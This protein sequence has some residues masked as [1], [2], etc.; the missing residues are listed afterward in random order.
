MPRKA[1]TS[2]ESIG[3]AQKVLRRKFDATVLGAD[4]PF[5]DRIGGLGL[6]SGDV[7]A[8]RS[9]LLDR[10]YK[11]VKAGAFVMFTQP[12][13]RYTG[14]G[15]TVLGVLD[16]QSPW[17]F[18][19]VK[20]QYDDEARIDLQAQFQTAYSIGDTVWWD[21]SSYGQSST[22]SATAP[23]VRHLDEL[24][25][26]VGLSENPVGS[27]YLYG[28][29]SDFAKGLHVGATAIHEH[30]HSIYDPNNTKGAI[31]LHAA[32]SMAMVE[33]TRDLDRL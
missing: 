25:V 26:P 27:E 32:A 16:S 22:R 8:N 13:S 11:S 9:D 19:E 21:H 20:Q 28:K 17:N 23:S 29:V 1:N 4:V 18:V 5:L 24:S 15:I 14:S 2:L 6:I 3:R 7:A 33:V 10:F 30:I 31:A 12:R